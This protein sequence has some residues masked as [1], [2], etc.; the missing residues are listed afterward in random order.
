MKR[1]YCSVCRKVKRVQRWPILLD[2]IQSDSPELRVG[3]CNYHQNP[4]LLL[5]Q[6]SQAIQFAKSDKTAAK[7]AVN[8]TKPE[9]RKRA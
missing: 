6:S 3:E 7:Q 2:N 5:R 4:S 1:F 8:Y 9:R